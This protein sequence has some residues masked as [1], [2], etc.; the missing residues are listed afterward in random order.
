MGDFVALNRNVL[1]DAAQGDITVGNYT[2]IG[3]NVVLRSSNHEF[4][5]IDIPVQM[6][7]HKPGKI[8][9]GRDVW[10]GANAVVLPNVSIGD[11][12]II[13]AGAVVTRDIPPGVIAGGV[14]ARV[15]RSR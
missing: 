6:Q 8:K 12:S 15:L 9:V 1:V 2:L 14:P 3:P 13:G 7:G 10:I 4:A 5:R 11:G